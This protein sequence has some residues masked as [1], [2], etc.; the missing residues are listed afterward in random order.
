MEHK[1]HREKM[2]R[3]KCIEEKMHRET[4]MTCTGQSGHQLKVLTA[5]KGCNVPN[6]SPL[7]LLNVPCG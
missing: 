7:H 6:S 4:T 5:Q 3:G 2:H 1:M